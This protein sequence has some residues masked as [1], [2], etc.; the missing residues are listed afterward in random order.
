MDPGFDSKT[1]IYLK[2]GEQDNCKIMN[3]PWLLTILG[4]QQFKHPQV[5]WRERRIR[6]VLDGDCSRNVEMQVL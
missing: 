6:K 3:T 2:K 5:F 1:T 4:W